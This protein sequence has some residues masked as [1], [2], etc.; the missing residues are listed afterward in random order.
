MEKY[1]KLAET[2]PEL[3]NNTN[4]TIKIITNKQE[5]MRLKEKMNVGIVYEDKYIMVLKDPVEFPNGK[6]GTYIRIL[7]KN[8]NDGV[9]ILPIYQ[10]KVVLLKDFR[11]ALRKNLLELPRGFCEDGLTIEENLK[12][13]LYEETGLNINSY[14]LIGRIASDSGMMCSQPYVYLVTIDD[15]NNIGTVDENEAIS[16][17]IFLNKEEFVKCISNGEIIDGFTL[18]AYALAVARE[19]F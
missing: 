2:R 16:N 6:S 7:Q 1:F 18:G 9:V 12:K 4:A 10:N 5:I 14:E 8:E 3:F 17:I 19:K 15:I 13:E 11:H